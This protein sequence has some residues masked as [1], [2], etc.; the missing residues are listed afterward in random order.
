MGGD[1]Y[2]LVSFAEAVTNLPNGCAAKQTRTIY[3][4]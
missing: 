1:D 2:A 3:Q 4:L